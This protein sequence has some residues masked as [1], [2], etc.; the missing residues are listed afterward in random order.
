MITLAADALRRALAAA[1]Q[2]PAL[3]LYDMM[4][5]ETFD[6]M[7][8]AYAPDGPASFAHISSSS[9]TISASGT[10]SGKGRP[11]ARSS[12]VVPTLHKRH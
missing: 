9:A 12:Y 5:V 7:R 10:A 2:L 3:L 1:A 4:Y 8:D 11:V 6:L